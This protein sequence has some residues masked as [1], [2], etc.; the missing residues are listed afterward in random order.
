[1]TDNVIKIDGKEYNTEDM[2]IQQKYI[3]VQ[4]RHLQN[5]SASLRSELDQVE[6]AKSSFTNSLIE[7]MNIKEEK[8]S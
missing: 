5:K 3:I 8:A 6:R 7:S 2:S 4:I 1:M